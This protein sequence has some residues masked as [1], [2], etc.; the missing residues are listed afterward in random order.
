MVRRHLLKTNLGKVGLRAK[1][2]D[3]GRVTFVSVVNHVNPL[4]D[5]ARS[6]TLSLWKFKPATRDG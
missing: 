5:A 2:D 6:L 1:I 3:K 4:L